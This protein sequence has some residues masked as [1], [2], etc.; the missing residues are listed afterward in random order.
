MNDSTDASACTVEQDDDGR[1]GVV[2]GE[3][4]E[5]ARY[6][7][8]LPVG[9]C[10]GAITIDTGSCLCSVC[11]VIVSGYKSTR[12]GSVL[13]V[14]GSL[15]GVVG[16]GREFKAERGADDSR[17]L[18][19]GSAGHEPVAVTVGSAI[20]T[21]VRYDDGDGSGCLLGVVARLRYL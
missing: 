2:C 8:R 18:R 20:G 11:N 7:Y 9:A 3:F 21:P 10:V 17:T 4:G 15:H 1:R 13:T 16:G 19:D 14:E 6:I 12:S 5:N